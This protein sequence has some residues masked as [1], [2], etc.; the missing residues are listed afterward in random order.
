MKNL[1]EKS[2]EVFPPLQETPVDQLPYLL[3]KFLQSVKKTN[4]EVYASA[5]LNTLFNGLCNILVVQYF[6][7]TQTGIA[8]KDC[9]DLYPFNSMTIDAFNTR[10]V[11]KPS[12]K[13]AL[14]EAP[15]KVTSKPE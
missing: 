1:S 6:G 12:L 14:V 2:V 15:K 4:G 8:R 7:S 10:N 9:R 11:K 5:S 13:K 3:L